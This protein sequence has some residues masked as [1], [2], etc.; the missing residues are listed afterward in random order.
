M[1]P[2]LLRSQFDLLEP[3]GAD[4]AGIALDVAA[5]PQEIVDAAVAYLRDGARSRVS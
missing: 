5:S 4:E 1:P 2:E 3:L